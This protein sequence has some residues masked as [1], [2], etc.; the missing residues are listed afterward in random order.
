VNILQVSKL[1]LIDSP[2]IDTRSIHDYPA[3]A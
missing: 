3:L 2:I 1:K